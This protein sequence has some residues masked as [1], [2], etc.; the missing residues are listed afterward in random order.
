MTT[1]AITSVYE[2][3]TIDSSETAERPRGP[4][5]NFRRV[6]TILSKRRIGLNDLRQ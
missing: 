4:V 3:L 6:V 5:L 2:A 1:N